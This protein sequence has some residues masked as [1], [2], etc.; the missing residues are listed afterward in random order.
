MKLLRFGYPWMIVWAIGVHV[1]WGVALWTNKQAASLVLLVG[2]NH[3]IDDA[4]ISARILGSALVIAALLAIVGIAIEG[5]AK[6]RTILAFLLPQ[7]GLMIVALLSDAWIMCHGLK[8]AQGV[9]INRVLL[10]TILGPMMLA[11]ALHT[12]SIIERFVLEPRRD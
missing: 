6:P 1:M 12:L 5:I 8:S 2:L 3:F 4:H 11:A 9:E 7:Y 10:M